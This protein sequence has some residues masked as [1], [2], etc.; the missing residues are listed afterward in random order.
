MIKKLI[1]LV[2]RFLLAL[3]C[4]TLL[5][6]ALY[7]VFF[8]GY[9][10]A[11]RNHGDV[12]IIETCSYSESTKVLR[13]PNRGFYFMYGF[14]ISD[15]KEEDYF[16]ILSKRF[17][18]SHAHSLVMIQINL[19]EYA[20]GPISEKGLEYI[21]NL[22]E[23]MSQFDK[24][25]LIR[26][27]YDWNGENINV[28]P[29]SVDI[30]L[31]HM[32][33]L[34]EIFQEYNDIIFIHQGLF[35]GNWGEMNGTMHLDSMKKL[36]EKLLE[37]TDNKIYLSVRMPA[38]W[39]KITQ[40]AEPNVMNYA[41]DHIVRR[42]GLFNDGMM[43]SYSDYGTYGKESRN[44]VGDFTHW[45]RTE[46]LIFQ[47]ELCKYVPNGGEVIKDNEYNDFQNA[48]N[49]LKQMHIT[50][51]NWDYDREVL[52]KWGKYIIKDG[53]IYNG[54]DGLTYIE[55]HLGYRL[56][57]KNVELGYKKK[58]DL[59]TIKINLQ[60]VGFAPVYKT[61]D[62]YLQIVNSETKSSQSYLIK[63]DIC[64]LTGGNNEESFSSIF[65]EQELAGFSEGTYDIYFM[66]KDVD[67]GLPIYL[68]NEQESEDYG[69]KLGTICVESLKES[70]DKYLIDLNKK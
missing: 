46:E 44:K 26:F 22:F 1:R 8:F 43:G 34:R 35:I 37:V 55:R 7:F 32:E 49:N 39:R 15:D 2:L 28:E 53:S 42:I 59:L 23:A 61:T 10:T 47:E 4:V 25:Y 57:I 51:L 6:V 48:L 14:R 38:Q 60:N 21:H 9:K 69:Y 67:S 33:Q 68:A 41:A 27:L 3:A 52:E 70:V 36:A 24:Q 65:H 58:E 56:L 66:I 13:N 63:T 18:S 31:N 29:E 12:T 54:M 16:N 11:A 19:Q 17:I 50:Y 45:N 62:A 20:D 40:I 5:L 64:K 30:I